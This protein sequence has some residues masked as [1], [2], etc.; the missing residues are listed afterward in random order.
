MPVKKNTMHIIFVNVFVCHAYIKFRILPSYKM[1]YI[2]AYRFF[3]IAIVQIMLENV[4]EMWL[5]KR[6]NVEQTH[7]GNRKKHQNLKFATVQKS[8]RFVSSV[9][10]LY[11][12]NKQLQNPSTNV[13]IK[14]KFKQISSHANKIFLLTRA[15]DY[16]IHDDDLRM[17][18]WEEDTVQQQAWKSSDSFDERKIDNLHR[19]KVIL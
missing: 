16:P 5:L 13:S 1:A 15:Q 3:K 17:W 6:T 18:T 19:N 7:G 4:S 11:D 12:Y 10:Q 14:W 2:C 8:L 9:S